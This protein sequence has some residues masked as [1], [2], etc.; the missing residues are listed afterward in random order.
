MTDATTYSGMPD[1]AAWRAFV[2]TQKSLRF[3]RDLPEGERL[4]LSS[5]LAF[6]GVAGVI[7]YL[8]TPVPFA[9]LARG[10][11]LYLM[12]PV[13][14]V[15]LVW[16]VIRV[17]EKIAGHRFAIVHARGQ[18]MLATAVATSSFIPIYGLFKQY[19]LKA[20]GFPMDATLAQVDRFFLFGSD[21]WEVTHHLFPSVSATVMLD[22][23][24]GVWLPLLMLCPVLWTALVADPIM[25]AR[26][27]ACWI[28]VWVIVGGVAAWLLASAGPMYY[29]HFIGQ[30]ASFSALHDQIVVQSQL[31]REAGK[32]VATPAGH[33][34]LMKRYESG[35]YMPGFGISAMPSVH[36]SMSILFAIGGFALRRWIGWALT[37]YAAIIWLGSIHLGW[38]YAADG[39]VGAALTIGMWK[40]SAPIAKSFERRRS[41]LEEDRL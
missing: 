27:I 22:R 35:I 14:S 13:V 39:I 5:M 25:R 6:I 9:S 1:R 41:A 30:D 4:F 28:G 17:A 16:G 10:M 38:H 24:Y 15:S 19:V 36:V 23:A 7:L 32:M 21:A 31:A 11:S 18:W 37:A 33:I 40:A 8:A 3:Q 29:P 34:L 26:L 2:P 20:R 12:L